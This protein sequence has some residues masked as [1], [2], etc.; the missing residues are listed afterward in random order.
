MAIAPSNSDDQKKE[1]LKN[2]IERI[3][4]QL[5]KVATERKSLTDEK[6]IVL[7]QELDHHLLKFQQETRK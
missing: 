4:Q 5:L 3:R 1:D 7:S 2:K 6:V